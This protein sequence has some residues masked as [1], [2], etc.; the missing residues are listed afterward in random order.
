MNRSFSIDSPFFTFLKKHYCPICKGQLSPKKKTINIDSKSVEAKEYDFS[1][2]D[3]FLVGKVKFTFFV[4]YCEICQEE[5][6]IKEIK[7][8]ENEGAKAPGTNV[9]S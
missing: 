7:Q 5:Y 2:G 4:L 8:Q 6:S 3:T 9:G 1:C